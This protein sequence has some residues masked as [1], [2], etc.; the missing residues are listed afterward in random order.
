M[1]A[2]NTHKTTIELNLDEHK[3]VKDEMHERGMTFKAMVRAA[4]KQYFKT[5]KR[6]KC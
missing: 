5:K 1:Q 6:S 4:L 3:K 2:K